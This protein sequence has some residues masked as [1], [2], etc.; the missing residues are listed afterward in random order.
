[1]DLWVAEKPHG[2][3]PLQILASIKATKDTEAGARVGGAAFERVVAEA[4][5]AQ[6]F[7]HAHNLLPSSRAARIRGTQGA[8]RVVDGP[9]A[10]TK[11]L[12]GGYMVMTFESKEEAL[13][14]AQ[15]Y[16]EIVGAEEVDVREVQ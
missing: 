13:A 6:V 9:F 7:V 4:R 14:F 8:R 15:R 10:E 3:V 1:L 12:L 11:E 2:D 5:E 16:A